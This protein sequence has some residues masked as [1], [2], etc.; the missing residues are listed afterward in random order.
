[1]CRC[2]TVKSDRASQVLQRQYSRPIDPFMKCHI[3]V[4]NHEFPKFEVTYCS[5]NTVKYIKIQWG[6]SYKVQSIFQ[7]TKFQVNWKVVTVFGCISHYGPLCF[8]LCMTT[9][10]TDLQQWISSSLQYRLIS[11]QIDHC[12]RVRGILRLQCM[13]PCNSLLFISYPQHVPSLCTSTMPMIQRFEKLWSFIIKL[14]KI[15]KQALEVAQNKKH[16]YLN[17][18]LEF[19]HP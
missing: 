16:D 8:L 1:M 10:Q 14:T 7:I 18:G 17:I 2:Q 5:Q 11:F 9:S 15:L 13:P 3:L 4:H 12:L 19:I 6:V